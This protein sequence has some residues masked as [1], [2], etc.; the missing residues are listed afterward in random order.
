MYNVSLV[1][2]YMHI[3]YMYII[4]LF[5]VGQVWNS[6]LINIYTYN[7]YVSLYRCIYMQHLNKMVLFSV[8]YV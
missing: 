2:E 7:V 5:Y 6:I 4:Y 3:L 1:Y 8:Y